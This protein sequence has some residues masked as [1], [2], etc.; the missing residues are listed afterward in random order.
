MNQDYQ[1]QVFLLKDSAGKLQL[2]SIVDSG[3]GKL[4]HGYESGNMTGAELIGAVDATYFLDTLGL[5]RGTGN[6]TARFV[7]TGVIDPFLF[8]G[9]LDYVVIMPIRTER[10]NYQ[11][12][13]VMPRR[14]AVPAV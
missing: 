4:C 2:A 9:E 11:P 14:R 1:N 7:H 5:L 10:E 8:I 6:Q 12:Q 3:H 13:R